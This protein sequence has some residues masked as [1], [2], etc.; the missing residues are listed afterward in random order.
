MRGKGKAIAIRPVVEIM[1]RHLP[2]VVRATGFRTTSR[3][4]I[5]LF[6]V[7]NPSK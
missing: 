3:D 1:K 2:T 6:E 4:S 7:P 5:R